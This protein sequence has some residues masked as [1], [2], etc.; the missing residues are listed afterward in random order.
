MGTSETAIIS[1]ASGGL[2]H[3]SSAKR[4]E[5][6]ATKKGSEKYYYAKITVPP[7]AAGELRVFSTDGAPVDAVLCHDGRERARYKNAYNSVHGRDEGEAE[8]ARE[9]AEDAEGYAQDARDAASAARTLSSTDASRA[10]DNA[11]SALRTAETRLTT[12]A[13]KLDT[14]AGHLVTAGK[15]AIVTTDDPDGDEDAGLASV[16][17]GAARTAA[18]AAKTAREAPEATNDDP[19]EEITALDGSATTQAATAFDAAAAALITAAEALEMAA[20]DSDVHEGFQLRA[21]VKSDEAEYILVAVVPNPDNPG[22]PLDI[23]AA[24]DPTNPTISLNVRFHGAL[25]TTEGDTRLGGQIANEGNSIFHDLTVTAPGLLTITAT[26]NGDLKGELRETRATV[27][28]LA[29][30]DGTGN[31][32]ILAAPVAAGTASLAVI[33]QSRTRTLDY[34]LA[35]TFVVAISRD[36]I[37]TRAAENSD[38]AVNIVFEDAPSW[39]DSGD[40]TATVITNDDTPMIQIE[41]RAEDGNVADQDVFVFAPDHSGLLA[42]NGDSGTG[43]SS[44]T[45][46]ALYGPLGQIAT[47]AD[48]GPGNHFGFGNIPVEANKR[49]AVVVTGTDGTYSLQADLDPITGDQGTI[50]DGTNTFSMQSIPAT[51]AG[52]A[53]KERNRY[54]FRIAHAGTL[55]LRTTGHDDVRGIL[56]GPDGS[57][58]KEDDNT[59]ENRNFSIAA[60]VQPGLY[61]LEVDSPGGAAVE[62]DLSANFVRGATVDEPGDTD[63]GGGGGNGGGG[64]PTD[65]DPDP[66]D[67]PEPD[68]HGILEEPNH[69]EDRTGA[70]MVRGWVCQDDGN[71]VRIEIRHARGNRLA[72]PAFIVPFGSPRP[73]VEDEGECDQSGNAFGFGGDF[74]PES[75][76]CRT[77]LFPGLCGRSANRPGGRSGRATT[78]KEPGGSAPNLGRGVS[79]GRGE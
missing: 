61:M 27:P 29:Q 25:V 33:S 13:G 75:F 2:I 35:M 8:D 56:Y 52:Q 24:P 42:I 48:A 5:G 21:E 66:I 28:P 78:A 30:A 12:I 40:A 16:A 68:P 1:S 4:G 71:G 60:A 3:T 70:V 67:D 20:T 51:P 46:G 37:E 22:D 41:R 45:A 55:Y 62:Y 74:Q 44:N 69:L 39:G 23:S 11:R 43:Q 9:D 19:Q 14:V 73:D 15:G 34:S 53:K 76:G 26:S 18:A 32:F 58:V 50:S 65:P 49:Y 6:T 47:D 64:T 17:A 38:P 10:E 59:G 57:P 36:D 77:L 31:S 72:I 7:L 63:D 54:L 79:E